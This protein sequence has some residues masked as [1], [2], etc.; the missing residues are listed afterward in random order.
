MEKIK[1]GFDDLTVSEAHQLLEFYANM[2]GHGLNATVGNVHMNPPPPAASVPAAAP[3]TGAQTASVPGGVPSTSNS[4]AAANTDTRGVPWDERYHSGTA[5]TPGRNDN[6]SWKKRRGHDPKALGEYEAQY[7]GNGSGAPA[8]TAPSQAGGGQPA[9]VANPNNPLSYDGPP[10]PPPVGVLPPPGTPGLSDFT[11][12]WMELVATNRATPELEAW[13]V[14]T[15]GGHPTL[16]AA[17]YGTDPVKRHA[18]Y[19]VMKGYR[20]TH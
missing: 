3:S 20:L 16:N 9:P 2:K 4:T 13:I 18:V 7:L 15:Y 8:S 11:G 14:A 1:L 6:G 17:M 10:P 19:E 5:A 12:L